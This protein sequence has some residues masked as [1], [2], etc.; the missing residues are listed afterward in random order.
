M[1]LPPI[2]T[3]QNQESTSR[4]VHPEMERILR[5]LPAP[6]HQILCLP[7]VWENSSQRIRTIREE[8]NVETKKN[9]KENK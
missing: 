8:K 5:S 3:N 7:F 9:N 1:V 4:P 2:Y 6:S